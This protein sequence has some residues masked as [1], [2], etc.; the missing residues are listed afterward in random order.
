[1]IAAANDLHVDVIVVTEM[2][3]DMIDSGE[4]MA[5]FTVMGFVQVACDTKSDKPF[6]TFIF[7]RDVPVVRSVNDIELRKG[8]DT[9]ANHA[10]MTEVLLPGG[11]ALRIIGFH[12]TL[13]SPWK[14]EEE[15]AVLSTFL[16]SGFDSSTLVIGNSNMFAGQYKLPRQPSLVGK[17]LATFAS[18]PGNMLRGDE[19]EWYRSNRP[20]DLFNGDH[21]M[22]APD[23][24]WFQPEADTGLHA[25]CEVLHPVTFEPFKTRDEQRA[26]L[27][28]PKEA[29]A[30]HFPLLVTIFLSVD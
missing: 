11:R 20:E 2:G 29:I 28:D 25:T 27:A 6:S 23:V 26:A 8:F 18:W 12:G 5:R 14:I 24:A 19:L 7:V 1:M 4:I 21:V 13:A 3:R 10:P 9:D 16:E 17:D 30:G 15:M 22:S